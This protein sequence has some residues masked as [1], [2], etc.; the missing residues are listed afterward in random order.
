MYVPTVQHGGGE[1][2][3]TISIRH[4]T[5]TR[6]G[7]DCV[8]HAARISTHARAMLS[9]L[10]EVE[11]L[12]GLLLFVRTLYYQ[13]STW[14]GGGRAIQQEQG[15]PL[16]V[17]NALVQLQD[18]DVIFAFLDDV[19]GLS[20]PEG[21]RISMICSFRSCLTLLA[22]LEQSWRSTKSD[23]GIGSVGVETCRAEEFWAHQWAPQKYML[24]PH[25]SACW[26]YVPAPVATI[27][28][29]LSRR[30]S[31]RCTPTVM[32]VAWRKS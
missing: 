32:I 22:S 19:N 20:T 21:R 2:L 16:A 4:E 25:G 1:G 29:A 18:G 14:A 31:L 9:K 15:D 30:S 26:C 27:S 12:R 8:G 28:S 11:S 10:H 3:C 5:S 23:G 6:A 7:R 24:K 17:Q 13:P